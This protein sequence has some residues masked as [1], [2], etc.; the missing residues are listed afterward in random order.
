MHTMLSFQCPSCGKGGFKN[1]VAVAHHMSQPRSG[2]SMWLQDL[3]C[4]RSEPDDSHM[5]SDD[6]PNISVDMN[7]GLNIP[8]I[9]SGGFG[10][11]DQMS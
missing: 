2:C 11:W 6:E 3:V 10:D 7:D 8:D 9:E 1:N 5:D 4:L